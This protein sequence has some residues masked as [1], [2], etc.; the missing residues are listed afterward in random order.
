M[1][2]SFHDAG[3]AGW[4]T[5]PAGNNSTSTSAWNDDLK[6]GGASV[7]RNLILLWEF[8]V[9][10]LTDVQRL[11]FLSLTIC[12]AIIAVLGNILVIYVNHS[13]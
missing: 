10:P 1:S 5:I 3:G 6:D 12:V 9:Q 13:R 4:I 2:S 7:E 8:E 11:I